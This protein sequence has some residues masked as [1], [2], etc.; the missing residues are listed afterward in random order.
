MMLAIPSPT[1]AQ[2]SWQRAGFGV[3]LHFGINTFHGREWSDGTLDP[4]AFNP[5]ELDAAQWVAHANA[6]G[7]ARVILTAKHHDGF[8]LWPT[9][10]TEYSVRA[11][12]W[13]GGRGDVVGEL[14]QACRAAGM[15]LGLYLSPWDRNAACYPDPDAYDR[16]YRR[17]LTELCTRYGP[18]E[19]LWFDGAGSEGR[20][21]DWAGIMDVID[22]HQPQ[23]M[24][25]N[26]G[27][28]TIRWVG[29]E[30]GLASDPCVYA[31]ERVGKSIYTEDGDDLGALRYLPPEC[32]VPIRAHWFWQPDDLATLKS[33]EHLLAIWYRSIGMGA[34]LLLNVPPDRRGLLDDSDAARLAEVGAELDRRFAQPISPARVVQDGPRITA[35][36]DAPVRF[37]HLEL[38]EDL[39]A[40]QRVFEHEVMA[41]GRILAAAGTVGV[42]RWHA[43]AETE[44][45]R[46]DLTLSGPAARLASLTAHRTGIQEPPS[47]EAQPRADEDKFE[48]AKEAR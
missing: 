41:D 39:S 35:S 12:P 4:R 34:G 42:R 15:G 40:G 38:C 23:A 22:R 45:A 31:V 46:L 18:L 44:A 24:V 17:Q 43:F 3:F 33:R 29:N 16:Y 19:E 9:S 36:F 48:H 32:D 1:A 10:T 37:D 20:T 11:S 30:D 25:F 47:L 13:R 5:T 27:R 26:M 21:Y 8:C 2:L 7:A 28:P 14:A 6:A